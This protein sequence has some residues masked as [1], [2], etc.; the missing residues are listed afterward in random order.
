MKYV[1]HLG[2]TTISI[3]VNIQY[4]PIVSVLVCLV[5]HTQNLYEAVVHTAM[6]K[7][8]LYYNAVM[9]KALDEGVG[10]TLGNLHAVI[11]V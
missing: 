11:V 3:L 8:Y 9:H 7:R 6:K 5:K 2:I 4:L 10:Y 1:F